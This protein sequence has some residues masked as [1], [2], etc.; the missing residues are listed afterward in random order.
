MADY[1]G[2]GIDRKIYMTEVQMVTR[3]S[4]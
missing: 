4:C 3:V 1:F 2:L